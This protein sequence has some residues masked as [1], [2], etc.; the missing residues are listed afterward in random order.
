MATKKELRRLRQIYQEESTK[1]LMNHD[2][3]FRLLGLDSEI[4]IVFVEED[5]HSPEEVTFEMLKDFETR[6]QKEISSR[7]RVGILYTDLEAANAADRVEE[8]YE[9]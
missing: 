1:I 4:K 6:F 7:W 3:V 2:V 5:E 9:I 8:E